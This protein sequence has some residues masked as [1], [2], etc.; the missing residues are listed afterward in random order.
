MKPLPEPVNPEP[1]GAVST[2]MMK[3]LPLA[4][5]LSTVPSL[6][7]LTT[8]LTTSALTTPRGSSSSSS[9]DGSEAPRTIRVSGEAVVNVVPDVARFTLLIEEVAADR[10]V[11][12]TATD[13]ALQKVLAALTKNGVAA[14]DL[15]TQAPVFSPDYATDR[16]GQPLYLKVLSWRVSRSIVVCTH[17][18]ASLG[19]LQKAAFD[20]GARSDGA[21]TFDTTKIA[22]LRQDVRRL[23]AQAARS[24]A[25]LL[26]DE[27]GGSLGLPRSIDEQQQGWSGPVTYKNAVENRMEGAAIAGDFAAGKLSLTATVNVTFDIEG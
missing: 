21:I 2:V 7:L 23:A 17:E 19:A 10:A 3:L 14:A 20:A 22:E 11:A 5:V 18:L 27:L 9:S 8:Q 4:L 6:A 26:V 12:A 15:Q 1:T 24:K 16:F 13:V 25:R